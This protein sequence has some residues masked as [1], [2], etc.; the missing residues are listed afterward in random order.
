MKKI[1][2]LM[3]FLL[4]L[5]QT[6]I[7]GVKAENYNSFEEVEFKNADVKFLDDWNEFDKDAAKKLVDYKKKKFIGWNKTFFH[8]K[9]EFEF[10]ADT[11]YKVKNDGYKDITHSYKYVET[12]EETVMRSVS[13]NLEISTSVTKDKEFKFGLEGELEGEYKDTRKSS[14]TQTDNVKIDIAPGCTLIITIEGKGYVTQ[15]YAK[16]FFFFIPV[17]EGG[18]EFVVITTQYYN[19]IMEKINEN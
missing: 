19:I 15:G 1:L 18:F 12:F 7:V 13:G 16:K 2:I 10:I 4:C 11:L 5:L 6:F 17:K 8:Y 3:L 9:E 14:S